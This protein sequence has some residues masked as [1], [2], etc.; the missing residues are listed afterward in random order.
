MSYLHLEQYRC[1]FSLD[2]ASFNVERPALDDVKRLIRGYRYD[3]VTTWWTLDD[4]A[5]PTLLSI[6]SKVNWVCQYEDG[7]IWLHYANP[8]TAL[9]TS[10]CLVSKIAQDEILQIEHT[11]E[12]ATKYAARQYIGLINAIVLRHVGVTL[13][14]H[15]ATRG[16]AA[17]NNAPAQTKATS[18]ATAKVSSVKHGPSRQAV[19]DIRLIDK[20]VNG[21]KRF[22]LLDDNTWSGYIDSSA[23]ADYVIKRNTEERAKLPPDLDATTPYSVL[24]VTLKNDT[25]DPAQ[26]KS[27]YRRLSKIY[28]PDICKA[29]NA[30]ELFHE[31]QRA[32]EI[33]S[34]PLE[35]E[36]AHRALKVQIRLSGAVQRRIIE[37]KGLQQLSPINIESGRFH[38][39][40]CDILD[41]PGQ[42]FVESISKVEPITRNGKTY[43]VITS[44]KKFI[45][46]WV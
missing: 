45:G 11:R 46:T 6:L 20:G 34:D 24:A 7:T 41:E 35:C 38:C 29:S 2:P 21:T 31:V 1:Y 8:I 44:G 30:A 9:L 25:I 4:N 22:M 42:I 37:V 26:I 32:Y 23:L 33:L 39:T 18:Q 27:Q 10:E 14:A 40:V 19:L 17:S 13:Q 12:L 15:L 28:H 5:A 43:Q 16:F 36:R 3:P